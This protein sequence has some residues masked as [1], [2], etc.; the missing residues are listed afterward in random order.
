MFTGIVKQL[1]DI[2]AVESQD[3]GT[4]LTLRALGPGVG[5][6]R[7]DSVCVNGVCLTA[8]ADAAPE[9]GVHL[10]FDV[11]AQTLQVST[12][13]GL[14]VGDQVNLEPA[15]CV[16]EPL[17]GHLVQGH[18]DGVGAVDHVQTDPGNWRVRVRLPEGPDA[19]DLRAAMVPK[20]SV[21]IDGVSLT[22]AGVGDD[23]IEVALIPE[24]LEKTT[25][26]VAQVG[27][28]VNLEAD[29]LT[30]AVV[31]VAGCRA[32]EG[33]DVQADAGGE[34]TSTA[35]LLLTSGWGGGK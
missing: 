4:R 17:G 18:V 35:A 32:R 6:K 25:L 33:A 7:G 27:T 23:W 29:V 28:R 20:G 15:L 8:C 3:A 14:A 22:L 30:K 5:A 12:L 16:G 13:G 19:A 24:T 11:I 26:G 34:P 10:V 21:T 31:R 9:A 1:G 2:V